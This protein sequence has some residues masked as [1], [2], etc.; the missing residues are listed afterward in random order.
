MK[1]DWHIE[2]GNAASVV[3]L[4]PYRGTELGARRRAR[5]IARATSPDLVVSLFMLDPATGEQAAKATLRLFGEGDV[6]AERLLC[7]ENLAEA[8][9]SLNDRGDDLSS[10]HLDEAE[11]E[12]R[13][14]RDR[15]VAL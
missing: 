12:Y 15:E 10:R 5:L 4:E 11:S 1:K 6:E 13:S 7:A 3:A 8:Y 9:V 14:L 2:V